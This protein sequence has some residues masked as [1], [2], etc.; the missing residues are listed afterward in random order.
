MATRVPNQPTKQ[1]TNHPSIQAANFSIELFS[2]HHHAAMVRHVRSQV[3]T[4]RRTIQ[5]FVM[6]VEKQLIRR[7]SLPDHR[8]LD[9]PSHMPWKM[10]YL[11]VFYL[12]H[13]QYPVT[14]DLGQQC[15]TVCT[16]AWKMGHHLAQHDETEVIVWA[17]SF[18]E[19]VAQQRQHIYKHQ[20]MVG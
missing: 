4:R 18:Q 20:S 1:P 6:C 16:W 12:A 13:V 8:Q 2:I 7:L 3:A 9:A 11:F 10:A 17:K 19:D 5:R 14:T 15:E